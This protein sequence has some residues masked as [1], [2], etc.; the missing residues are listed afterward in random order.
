MSMEADRSSN[1]CLQPLD[2]RVGVERR[3]QAGHV[4]DAE[5][6]RPEVL[7]LLGK[8]DEVIQAVNRTQG[9]T[10]GR[11]HV[12]AAGFDD[13]HGVLHVPHIVQSIE[14]SEDVDAVCCRAFDEVLQHVVGIMPI[15]H[16]V[17]PTEEH[18]QSGFRHRRPER[19][20]TLPWIFLE[21][22]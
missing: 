8:L 22:A 7:Q 9:I 4:F 20:Q 2:Q 19:A 1:G 18:L 21:E 12:L 15:S 10:D 14:D 6:V 11:F 3:Q 17:L 16:D 13:P 5:C